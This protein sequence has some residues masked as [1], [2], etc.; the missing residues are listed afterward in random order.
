[1]MI[2]MGFYTGR[3]WHN[4]TGNRHH[5]RRIGYI[6]LLFSSGI[7]TLKPCL[8]SRVAHLKNTEILSQHLS[9][10]I[11]RFPVQKNNQRAVV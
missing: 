6:L 2:E 7:L 10:L 5:E 8:E 3:F 9:F 11:Q 1:M 4:L